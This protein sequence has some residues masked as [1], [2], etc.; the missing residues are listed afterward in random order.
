MRTWKDAEKEALDLAS[1]PAALR[2]RLFAA[3]SVLAAPYRKFFRTSHFDLSR[4]ALVGTDGFV[5]QWHV[6]R[7]PVMPDSYENQQTSVGVVFLERHEVETLK[8]TA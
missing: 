4:R 7:Y 3:K 6:R 5:L 8:E 1:R 2:K